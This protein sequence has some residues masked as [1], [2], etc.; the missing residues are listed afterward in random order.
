MVHLRVLL[1]PVE[2]HNEFLD[3]QPVGVRVEVAEERVV[4]ANPIVPL[5]RCRCIETFGLI[6]LP[7]IVVPH[8]AGFHV[9][10]LV[11]PDR[12]PR[13]PPLVHRIGP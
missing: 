13:Y 3:P 9:I 4:A 1:E 5:L 7:P 2:M 12:P 6:C 8:A 10:R 11:K